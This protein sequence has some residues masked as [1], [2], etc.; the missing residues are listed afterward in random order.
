MLMVMA[1]RLFVTG[2]DGRARSVEVVKFDHVGDL[3]DIGELGLSLAQ[4]RVILSR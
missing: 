3:S 2:A 1:L 4:A